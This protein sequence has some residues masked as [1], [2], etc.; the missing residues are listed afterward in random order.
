[1]LTLRNTR[2]QDSEKLPI[3]RRWDWDPKR[4]MQFWNCTDG[5]ISC[6][7]KNWELYVSTHYW[8]SRQITSHQRSM[9][10][11]NLLGGMAWHIT[12]QRRIC[13]LPGSEKHH[14]ILVF[15]V[16]IYDPL[17]QKLS[18]KY[19]WVSHSNASLQFSSRNSKAT[20]AS[21]DTLDNSAANYCIKYNRN[22]QDVRVITDFLYK[23]NWIQ[24]TCNERI[25][26]NFDC[27]NWSFQTV[28]LPKR[29]SIVWKVQKQ[30]CI[31]NQQFKYTENWLQ[32][33][34]SV[35]CHWTGILNN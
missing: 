3:I 24:T 2:I 9:S 16:N 13:T 29:I 27:R 26:A 10:T 17:Q 23:F 22:K 35:T 34:V 33:V 15:D 4:Q 20:Q 32:K 6:D 1:M 28:T 25:A 12:R 21:K 19:R 14:C 31:R 11:F 5:W 30:T 7:Q 18:A 8:K